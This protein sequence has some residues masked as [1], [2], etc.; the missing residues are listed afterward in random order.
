[1]RRATIYLDEQLHKAL[2]IKAF[3]GDQSI[4]DLVNDAVRSALDEDLE[5]LTEIEARKKEK[6]VTYASFLKELKSRGQI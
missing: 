1:M 6:P 2:K 3:E 5:D 4:S